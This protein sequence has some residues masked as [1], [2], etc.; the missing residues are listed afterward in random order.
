MLAL[1]RHP[2]PVMVISGAI[3]LITV[4]TILA[5][6]TFDHLGGY[7]PC[8]LCLQQRYAYYFGVPAAAAAWIA[9]RL[10]AT[11]SAR[12]LLVL[13]ALAFLINAG[14]GSYH[15]GVEWK[16]W[17]GPETCAGGAELEW[18]EGGLSEQLETARVVRCDKAPWHFLGL[19]F[20]GWNAVISLLLGALAIFGATRTR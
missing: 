20:A 3:F 14:L 5:A 1:A 19:S 8:P 9:A 11:G 15:S 2:R 6:L 12:I 16:W 18:G 17:S 10:G 13:I 7:A 4:A